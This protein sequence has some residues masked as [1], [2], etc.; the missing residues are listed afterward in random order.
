MS[1]AAGRHDRPVAS[2]DLILHNGRG[3]QVGGG[4]GFGRGRPA[5]GVGPP[6]NIAMTFFTKG[7]L[8]KPVAETNISLNGSNPMRSRSRRSRGPR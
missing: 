2:D 6:H 4:H 8:K 1:P 5:G 7:P 3:L